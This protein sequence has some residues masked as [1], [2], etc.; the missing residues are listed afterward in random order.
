MT[1]IG[2]GIILCSE[3]VDTGR[4]WIRAIRKAVDEHVE[5]RKT[6]RKDSSKRKPM[7]KREVKKFEKF[8]A[9]LMSPTEKK[10]VS[11]SSFSHIYKLSL[12][13][14][15]NITLP[16]SQ[17]FDTKIF[18]GQNSSMTDISKLGSTSDGCFKSARLF[19][20]RKFSECEENEN[21]E[22]TFVKPV[23]AE[24]RSLLSVISDK[25]TFTRTKSE[26]QTPRP[27][28]P[29]SILSP[30]SSYRSFE[31]H[32]TGEQ[33]YSYQHDSE[34]GFS[35]I[36]VTNRTQDDFM[37]PP[38]KKRVKFDE[39]NI[40][41]SSITYQRQQQQL[42]LEQLKSHTNNRSLFTKIIDYTTSLF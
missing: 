27:S 35:T 40:V 33:N 39:E 21:N 17:N 41:V 34:F 8:E 36:A 22:S 9:E 37:S 2:E 13:D 5:T 6:L 42:K 20:K 3:D 24:K 23:I 16:R 15:D 7:R 4:A 25:L 14:S 38:P 19:R 26:L 10:N 28:Q 32:L 31:S 30:N 29:R 11:F 18:Y 1:C 12:F